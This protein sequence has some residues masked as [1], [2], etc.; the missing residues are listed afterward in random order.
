MRYDVLRQAEEIVGHAVL[1]HERAERLI[2]E[3]MAED[4][5][6][7]RFWRCRGCDAYLRSALWR[8]PASRL[9]PWCLPG[10]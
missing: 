8:R 3:R 5:A 4:L 2:A 9:C 10:S 1:S 7:G 6:V